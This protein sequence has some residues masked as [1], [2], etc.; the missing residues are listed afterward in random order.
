M[1]DPKR[2]LAIETLQHLVADHARGADA[3]NELIGQLAWDQLQLDSLR[4]ERVR[5]M[6]T[7]NEMRQSDKQLCEF[8]DEYKAQYGPLVNP[9]ETQ[10]TKTEALHNEAEG[11]LG[12]GC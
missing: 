1:A 2:L 3:L 8:L 12:K 11:R 7:L 4:A 10:R 5:T 6:D 9:V